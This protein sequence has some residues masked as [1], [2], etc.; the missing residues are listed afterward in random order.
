MVTV[1][2]VS[3]SLRWG[4]LES[5]SRSVTVNVSFGSSSTSSAMFTVKSL[6]A[7]YRLWPLMVWREKSL[8]TNDSVSDTP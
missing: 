6:D 5:E 7:T 2:T 4:R 8:G 3:P 1:A